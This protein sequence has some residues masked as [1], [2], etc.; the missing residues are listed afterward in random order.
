MHKAKEWLLDKHNFIFS[1]LCHLL[2]LLSFTIIWHPFSRIKP[3]PKPDMYLPSYVYQQP[4]ALTSPVQAAHTA[5]KTKAASNPEGILKPAAAS[6]SLSTT[7]SS[8]EPS[9]NTRASRPNEGIRL[10]G[11]KGVTAKPLIK[12]L[13]RDLSSHL[14]YP[15]I[16][17]DF[18]VHGVA[19]IGFTL[20]PDGEMT[21]IRLVQSSH[22][23][24][25]DQA[26]LNAVQAMRPGNEVGKYLKQ[27]KFLVVG[28]I[29]G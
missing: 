13:A 7:Q 16:A 20:H 6:S 22:A 28:I 8:T 26:A 12:L 23:S 5:A 10:I 3:E 15:K 9:P 11:D 14:V 1:L 4:A 19:Y 29:F 2:L 18:K 21:D 24:I 25:L 17:A 27:A